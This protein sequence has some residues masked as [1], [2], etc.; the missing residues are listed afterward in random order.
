MGKILILV[1]DDDKGMRDILRDLLQD[2]G[3]EV[4]DAANP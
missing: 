3:Y 4:Y 2:D 1:V